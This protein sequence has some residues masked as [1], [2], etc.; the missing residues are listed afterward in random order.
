[1]A[2]LTNQPTLAPTRKLWAVI[3]TGAIMGVLTTL[4]N[5]YAPELAPNLA[6][7]DVWVSGAVMTLAGYLTRNRA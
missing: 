4:V 6:G 5:R 1:M 7:V 2:D 3:I